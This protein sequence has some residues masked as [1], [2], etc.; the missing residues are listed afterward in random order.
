[1]LSSCGASAAVARFPPA[2]RPLRVHARR[3]SFLPDT[4]SSALSADCGS[5]STAPPNVVTRCSLGIC[6]R[7]FVQQLLLHSTQQLLHSAAAPIQARHQSDPTAHPGGARL[8][9]TP[10]T[11]LKLP[12]C[13]RRIENQAESASDGSLHH[14]YC[15]A[16]LGFEQ[17]RMK[18]SKHMLAL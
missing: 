15:Q 6:Q 5:A 1:M 11:L 4:A 14:N 10:S 7:P 17:M 8:K 18:R 12:L 13:V 16:W 2:A 3:H 9:Y